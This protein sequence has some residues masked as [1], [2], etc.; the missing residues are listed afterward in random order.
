LFG[1]AGPP[2]GPAWLSPRL[3]DCFPHAFFERLISRVSLRHCEWSA[4]LRSR[5]E[6]SL[7][8]AALRGLRRRSPRRPRR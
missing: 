8:P 2:D 4:G 7:T 1:G 3:P 5:P 6:C